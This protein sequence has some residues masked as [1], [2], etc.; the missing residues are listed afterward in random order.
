MTIEKVLNDLEAEIGSAEANE[1]E[2]G[3]LAEHVRSHLLQK[4]GTTD[5]EAVAQGFAFVRDY[6]REVPAL[7]REAL[8]RSEGTF[9]AD[10]MVRMVEAATT[11]WQ[12]DDDVIPD[13][14]GLWGI[15]DDAYCTLVLLQS[16]DDRYTE[17]TGQSLV[18][19]DLSDA[20]LAIRRLLG[21]SV[22]GQLEDFVDQALDDA[23]MTELLDSLQSEAL[24]P[25]ERLQ[26]NDDAILEMFNVL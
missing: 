13:H 7:L 22:A 11:Y 19:A 23:T 20:N 26:T 8:S 17:Q 1:A 4:N 25:P 6:I 10:K 21:P 12:A 16:L 2:S 5:D 24:P 3:H 18:A 9:A 15:L 14:Q